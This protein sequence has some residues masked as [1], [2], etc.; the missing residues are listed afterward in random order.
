MTRFQW[1]DLPQA[2]RDAIQDHAGPVVKAETAAAGL[3]PGV[4]A[5]LYLGDGGSVFLKAC[6]ADHPAATLYERELWAGRVLPAAVPTPRLRWSSTEHGW[7]AM[8]HTFIDGRAVDLSPGSPD[9]PAVLWLVAE[10]GSCPGDDAPPVSGNVSALPAKGRRLL[11]RGTLP[12][13][14]RYVAALDRW[15]VA[16]LEGTTLLHYDLHAG[17]P[18]QCRPQP[19]SGGGGVRHRPV[20]RRAPRPGGRRGCAAARGRPR[21]RPPARSS[22]RRS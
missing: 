20:P 19:L 10:L 6:P 11:D 22:R 18:G 8:L 16:G 1:E 3:M 2:V 12:D 4:A 21:R 14:A 9:V 13:Q 5:R 17:R 7:V 15:D